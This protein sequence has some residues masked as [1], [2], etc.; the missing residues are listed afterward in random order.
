MFPV[1]CLWVRS[2]SLGCWTNHYWN[3]I[4][5]KY[6]ST[7]DIHRAMCYTDMHMKSNQKQYSTIM[8]ASISMLVWHILLYPMHSD[9]Y[10]PLNSGL[11]SNHSLLKYFWAFLA[12]LQSLELCLDKRSP[13]EDSFAIVFHI[14]DANSFLPCH[15]S[16]MFLCASAVLMCLSAGFTLGLQL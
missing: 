1:W 12:L 4:I 2:S 3:E 10:R 5:Q 13:G 14:C 6:W 11:S 7:G 9:I 8:A 16:G 15:S